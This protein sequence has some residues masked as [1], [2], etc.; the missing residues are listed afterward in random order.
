MASL[1]RRAAASGLAALLSLAPTAPV[2]AVA[3]PA[4]GPAA[5]VWSMPAAPA[6]T[7]WSGTLRT[8]T[9]AYF[10]GRFTTLEATGGQD[11][12]TVTW[13]RTSHTTHYSIVVAD[14]AAMTRNVRTFGDIT[15]TS[16]TIRNVSHGSR[17]GMPNF[18]RLYAHNQDFR[19]RPSVRLTAYAAAPEVSGRE[20][21]SVA[22]WNILCAVCTSTPGPGTPKWTQRVGIIEQA[23]G[24]RKPDVLLLQE[25]G[26]YAV[27]GMKTRAM[28]DFAKRLK[29][30]GYALDCRPESRVAGYYSNR[31]AYST[32][33]FSLVRHGTFALPKAPGSNVRGAAWVLLKSKKTGRKF[34]A[35]SFHTDPHIPLTG[36]NSKTATVTR[37]DARMKSLNRQKLPVIIGGDMNSSFYQLPSNI[38]HETLM[39]LGW[40][41]AAS[42]AHTTNYKYPTFNGYRDQRQTWGRIDYILTKGIQGTVSYENVLDIDSSGQFTST[43]GSDHNM[44]LARVRLR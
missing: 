31:V 18:I 37:I 41:D 12:I 5:P 28:D 11:S 7:G 23:V 39:E 25:A 17:S 29:G 3:A 22:T 34:Y 4:D 20:Q 32:R 10:P 36:K 15:D 27:A 19:T 44:V 33:K 43:P 6:P 21:V 38:P 35:V 24:S 2:A 30:S 42:S 14:N 40:T 13:N 9:R 1:P 16:Y 8:G 26:N